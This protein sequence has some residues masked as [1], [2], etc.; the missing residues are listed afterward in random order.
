MVGVVHRRAQQVVHGRVQH[1]EPATLG[2]DMDVVHPRQQ[3][4]GVGRDHPA[5]LEGELDV[6][7][8][9]H[10]ADHGGIVAGR[11]RGWGIEI[12]HAQ[13]AAQVQT[14]QAKALGADALDQAA[15]LG[16]GGFHRGEVGDLAT[17]MTGH[18]D[19]AH[20]GHV[21]SV[22]IE[23]LGLREADAELVLGLARCDLGMA[24]G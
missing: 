19:G 14:F 20:P 23:P 3:D 4:A 16:E 18:A 9:H 22:G 13:A 2:A 10:P 15:H 6:Q 12:G 11:G 17:D 24:A 7:A 1:Q 5:R 8:L 21:R